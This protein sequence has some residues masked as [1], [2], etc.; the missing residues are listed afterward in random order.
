MET[1]NVQI[2][3]DHVQ[4]IYS[5]TKIQPFRVGLFTCTESV[6]WQPSRISNQTAQV[7]TQRQ[8]NASA[9]QFT[10]KGIG[11]QEGGIN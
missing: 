6:V 1:L 11:G 4:W 2:I 8:A 3:V 5:V 9:K 10:R 7:C